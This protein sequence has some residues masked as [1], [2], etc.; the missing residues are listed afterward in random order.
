MMASRWTNGFHPLWFCVIAL[1]R[2]LG[3]ELGPS[4]YVG[5]ALVSV[6]SILVT[7]ELGRRFARQL[8]ASAAVAAVIAAT[9]SV[10]TAQLLTAGMECTAAIPLFLC[11]L[12]AVARPA[13]LTPRRAAGL[14]LIA[15]LA[16]LARLDIALA[17]AFLMV[18]FAVLVRPPL[19]VLGRLTLAFCAGGALLPAYL[20]S[21]SRSSA[22]PSRRRPWPSSSI[23]SSA[24]TSNTLA[25]RPW[26]R[27]TGPPWPW[28][29]PSA[30]SP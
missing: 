6:A 22:P 5:L 19:A 8:G 2:R 12:V 3:G 1:L 10:S 25:W 16:I 7:Y 21:M 29:C 14:G 27:C 20:P 23:R 15:S 30:F 28:C 4:F 11:L 26:G 13:P 9:Y 18:G 24:S 17:V